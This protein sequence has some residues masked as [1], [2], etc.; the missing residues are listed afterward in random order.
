MSTDPPRA[1]DS[2]PPT[3]LPLDDDGAVLDDPVVFFAI[4]GAPRT[5]CRTRTEPGGGLVFETRLEGVVAEVRPGAM[6]LR[7]PARQALVR[8][9]LPPAVDLAPLLGQTVHVQVVQRFRGAGRASVLAVLRDTRQRV[10]L[11][12]WDGQLPPDGDVVGLSLRVALDPDGSR[13][14][15]TDTRRERSSASRL[16]WARIGRAT[17]VDV[18]E[19]RFAAV[20]LRIGADDVSLLLLRR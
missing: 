2:A 14:A 3:Q 1:R 18:E 7:Q 9:L 5:A 17:P 11:A 16:R 20:P 15:L 8:H 10:L 6:V 13:L 4:E 12:A 19:G